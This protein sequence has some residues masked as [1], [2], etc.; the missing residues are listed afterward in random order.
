MP[1]RACGTVVAFEP[2]RQMRPRG[3]PGAKWLSRAGLGLRNP[4]RAARCFEE[5]F[6]HE[7]TAGGI[8]V[9][10]PHAQRV[11]M[12]REHARSFFAGAT[13]DLEG[14]GGSQELLRVTCQCI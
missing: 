10:D 3:E 4:V 12:V 11:T 2:S 14:A 7:G 6:R 8:D 9:F 1:S 13:T 5:E